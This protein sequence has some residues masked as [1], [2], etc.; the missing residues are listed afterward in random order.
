MRSVNFYDNVELITIG[1]VYGVVNVYRLVQFAVTF[2]GRGNLWGSIQNSEGGAPADNAVVT[3]RIAAA[4][5]AR[6]RGA[7]ISPV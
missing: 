1:I 7:T 5:E 6:A 2:A 4:P 3:E